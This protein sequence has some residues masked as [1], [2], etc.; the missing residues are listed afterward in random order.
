MMSLILLSGPMMRTLRT[1]ADMAPDFE[2][3]TT[4]GHLCF[5]DWI[6]DSWAILFSYPKDFTPACTTE[7]AYMAK[8]KPEFD[9]RNVKIIGLSVNPVDTHKRWTNAHQGNT[10]GRPELSRVAIPT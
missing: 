7:L 8:L 2:A 6:S 1:V 9:K 10:R 3:D 5:H 4:E